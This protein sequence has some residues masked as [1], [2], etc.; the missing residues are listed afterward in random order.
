LEKESSTKKRKE[1]L[2]EI[3]KHLKK[4]GADYYP[5]M[6]LMIPQCDKVRAIYGM[7]EAQLALQIIAIVPLNGNCEDALKLKNYK[8]PGTHSNGNYFAD[9]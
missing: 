6:R 5:F 4:R 2:D 8:D 3:W 9:V 1:R 7:K